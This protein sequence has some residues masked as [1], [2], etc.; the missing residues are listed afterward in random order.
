MRRGKSCVFDCNVWYLG[1]VF[2][3][4]G[5]TLA[6]DKSCAVIDCG[7][8][9]IMPVNLTALYTNKC[10]AICTFE[11]ICAKSAALHIE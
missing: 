7:T 9:K 8:D 5:H 6:Y 3:I 2:K 4:D 11:G 10:I 1:V